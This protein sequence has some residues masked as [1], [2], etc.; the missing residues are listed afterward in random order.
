MDSVGIHRTPPADT[1]CRATDSIGHL[2]QGY[3]FLWN[4]LSVCSNSLPLPQAL[5][6]GSPKWKPEG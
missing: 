6:S 2:L 3:G 1:S 4:A 5:G